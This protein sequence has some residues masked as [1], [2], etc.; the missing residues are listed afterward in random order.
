ML[1]FTFMGT[2]RCGWPTLGLNRRILR[3]RAVPPVRP[4]ALCASQIRRG[5]A[6]LDKTRFLRLGQQLSLAIQSC[7]PPPIAWYPY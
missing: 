5:G 1:G 7:E 6:M 4:P 2:A 3:Y